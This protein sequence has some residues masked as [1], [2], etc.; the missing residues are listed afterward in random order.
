MTVSVNIRVSLIHLP[1]PCM[2][3]RLGLKIS[4]RLN[5]PR[6]ALRPGLKFI[7]PS[8][9][10]K[11][12]LIHL[13]NHGLKTRPQNFSSFIFIHLRSVASRLGLKIDTPTLRQLEPEF[14]RRLQ[15]R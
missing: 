5:L 12:C 15:A 4:T 14:P 9:Y 6:L 8:S 13:N 3:S 10:T 7:Q 2:A 1:F 11:F